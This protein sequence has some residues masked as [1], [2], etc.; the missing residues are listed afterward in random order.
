MCRGTPI[1]GW[2]CTLGS[3]HSSWDHVV[4]GYSMGT[5]VVAM[6]DGVKGT[7]IADIGIGGSLLFGLPCLGWFG[8]QYIEGCEIALSKRHLTAE[9]TGM[10]GS[11]PQ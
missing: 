1:V 10:C 4:F 11:C 9:A 5:S 7:A 2:V 8:G 6:Y 3:E